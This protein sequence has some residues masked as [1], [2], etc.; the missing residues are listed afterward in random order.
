MLLL[1]NSK[2]GKFHRQLNTQNPPPWAGMIIMC[3]PVKNLIIHASG[4]C[5]STNSSISKCWPEIMNTFY[6][7]QRND[8]AEN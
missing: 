2:C 4:N 7:I 6:R 1:S 8:S 5:L 3:L